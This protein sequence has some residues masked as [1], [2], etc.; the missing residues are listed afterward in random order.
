MEFVK[1]LSVLRGTRKISDEDKEV[2]LKQKAKLLFDIYDCDGDNV[3]SKQDLVHILRLMVGRNISE[4]QLNNIAIKAFKEFK[5]DVERGLTLDD[6][7][8]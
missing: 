6:M 5:V 2:L 7:Y 4:P 8:N 3:V 1:K